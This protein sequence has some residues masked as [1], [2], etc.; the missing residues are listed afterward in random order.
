MFSVEQ[1]VAND[2][3]GTL[4]LIAEDYKLSYLRSNKFATSKFSWVTSCDDA[5][6]LACG[7]AWPISLCMAG[8]PLEFWPWPMREAFNRLLS[9]TAEAVAREVV[10]D[11]SLPLMPRAVTEWFWYQESGRLASDKLAGVTLRDPDRDVVGVYTWEG[12][13]LLCMWLCGEVSF[14]EDTCPSA[15][16]QLRDSVQ[17]LTSIWSLAAVQRAATKHVD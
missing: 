4:R 5:I 9:I 1:L 3:Y 16:K 14:P 11:V 10:G 2:T 6:E 7:E 12:H 8:Q 17:A 13:A 15:F